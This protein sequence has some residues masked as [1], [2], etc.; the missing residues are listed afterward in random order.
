MSQSKEKILGIIHYLASQISLG[1]NHLFVAKFIGEAY[2]DNKIMGGDTIL[3]NAQLACEESSVL[4]LG[5]V[6]D[7]HESSQSIYY[8]L[9]CLEED[10][11]SYPYVNKSELLEQIKSHRKKLRKIDA[12]LPNLKEKRDKVI[13][14]LDKK[15][16]NQPETVFSYPPLDTE[17]LIP[18]FQMIRG[19][20]EVYDKQTE[21]FSF[22]IDEG[23]DIKR[24]LD[25]LIALIDKDKAINST[26]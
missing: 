7:K 17:S 1:W 5:K 13:A 12:I 26:Q 20:L 4:A 14:H 23:Q 9:N 2:R 10:P 25:Y 24:D 18:A 8:L 21:S 15:L 11:S 19:I 16:V 22:W 6:V 3:K